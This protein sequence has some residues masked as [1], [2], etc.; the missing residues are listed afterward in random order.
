MSR[1][2]S[3]L[4]WAVIAAAF[5]GP[6][7]ILTCGK[8]GAGYGLALAW[9]LPVAGVSVFVLQEAAARIAAASGRPLAETIRART[10]RGLAR[11]LAVALVAG[12]VILGC[13]A[14]E[15]GNLL[16]AAAGAALGVDLDPR[17]LAIGL[18]GIALALLASGSAARVA[19]LMG[20]SVAIM[21]VAFCAV[22]ASVL[23]DGVD[24]GRTSAAGLWPDGSAWIALAL[25]GTTV[26]PYNLF[27]GSGLAVGERVRDIRLGLAISVGLGTLVSVAVIVVGTAI[28]GSFSYGALGEALAD[29]AGGWARG[30]FAVGLLA[31]GLSSAVTAPLAAAITAAGLFGGG[32]REWGQR[33]VRFRGAWAAV[34]VFGTGVAVTGVDAATAIV[35]AQALNGMLLPLVAAF[36]V[37]AA[38]DRTLLRDRVNGAGAN[39]AAAFALAASTLVGTRGV[40]S[41]AATALGRDA[42][43]NGAVAIASV[44][45]AAA[46]GIP[47]ALAARRARRDDANVGASDEV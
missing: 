11:V 22:A 19:R 1:I 34:V 33:S 21:G 29:R 12:A 41:A 35:A 42:P 2:A 43:S 10:R 15:A 36:L 23:L 26:V 45:V 8:A 40:M 14:Y 20:A 3:I 9:I 16:G 38:N 13:A 18:G 31:A 44:A 47:V 4:M 25:F 17:W 46:L 37:V 24:S 6:G 39:V 30:G 7:T 27:L 32:G 28:E 5:I